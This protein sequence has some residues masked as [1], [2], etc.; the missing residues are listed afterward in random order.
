[1]QAIDNRPSALGRLREQTGTDHPE[2][3][4]LRCGD[5]RT[6]QLPE[7]ELINA[8]FALP[9]CPPESFPAL[10]HNIEQALTPQGLFAGHFFGDRDQWQNR[11]LTLHNRAELKQLLQGWELL[12]FEEHEWDG[13]TAT[14]HTKHWHLFAVVAR[15]R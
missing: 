2:R 11:N 9:F 12:Q 13:K 5:F 1:M 4:E 8:S 3:L 10:W 6:L 14:G 7:V 15:T